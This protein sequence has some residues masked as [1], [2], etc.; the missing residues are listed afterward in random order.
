MPYT[1]KVVVAVK[2]VNRIIQAD[3]ADAMAGCNPMASIRG[4]FLIPPPMPNIPA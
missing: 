3:V 4:P 1:E 2:L